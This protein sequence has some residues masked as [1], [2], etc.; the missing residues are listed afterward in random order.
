MKIH[1]KFIAGFNASVLVGA[2]LVLFAG[3]APATAHTPKVAATCDGVT[4][5]LTNYGATAKNSAEVIIDGETVED[6]T[7]GKE[8]I[9]EYEFDDRTVAHSYTVV[10]DAPGT[11]HDVDTSDESEPCPAPVQEEPPVVTPPVEEPPVVVPEMP[12]PNET[13]TSVDDVN[14]DSKTV[15]TTT[16]TVTTGWTLDE[17]SNTWVKA[18]PVT[19][20]KETVRDATEGECTVETPPTSV[21][22]PVEDTPPTP[23]SPPVVPPAAVTP[24]VT[25]PTTAPVDDTTTVSD[26]LP[27]TGSD[28]AWAIPLAGGLLLA[29]AALMLVRRTRRA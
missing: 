11:A 1:T 22:P 16:T 23:A 25:V 18:E 21:T 5:A 6:T 2:A 4:V 20:V 17:T 7:F 13:V 8:F 3:A 15:T 28:T 27:A 29:G 14:C 26:S 12:Q 10:V 24:P 19:T 9:E